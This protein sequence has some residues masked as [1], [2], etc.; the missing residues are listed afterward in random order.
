MRIIDYTAVIIVRNDTTINYPKEFLV[1]AYCM[2]FF[3]V[4]ERVTNS[5]ERNHQLDF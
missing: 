4:D 2:E 3:S 1:G 5:R